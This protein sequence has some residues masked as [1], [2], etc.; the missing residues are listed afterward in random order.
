MGEGAPIL[1]RAHGPTRRNSRGN[2][3][4]R[5]DGFAAA[6][7]IAVPAAAP[8]AAPALFPAA[9][10][11]AT[12]AAVPAADPTAATPAPPAA[13][14]V[15]AAAAVAGDAPTAV[16]GK[17]KVTASQ[18]FD[19]DDDDGLFGKPLQGQGHAKG[20]TSVQLPVSSA[21][22]SVAEPAAS[23][24]S[25]LFGDADGPLGRGLFRVPSP[26]G[27]FGETRKA[28]APAKL[29][30]SLFAEEPTDACNGARDDAKASRPRAQPPATLPEIEGT[31]GA[32]PTGPAP[33]P[34][35]A[36]SALEEGINHQPTE[37]PTI[38]P[39]SG[40]NRSGGATGALS[41]H[42]ALLRSFMG[43]HDLLVADVLHAAASLLCEAHES[44]S[45]ITQ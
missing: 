43:Q 32:L 19:D 42:A 33:T 45:I 29:S 20:Q 1:S 3:F 7:A 8:V 11:A 28:A 23:S 4:T 39:I 44:S 35:V 37:S 16:E 25:N 14:S 27:L 36:T 5:K 34:P 24:F 15:T 31:I 10:P 2:S 40:A 21:G 6:T 22:A 13:T 26:G 30:T 18:L 12:P 17:S 41:R 38:D 9:D